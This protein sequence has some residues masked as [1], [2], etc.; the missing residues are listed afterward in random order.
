MFWRLRSAHATVLRKRNFTY[1]KEVGVS[2]CEL[3]DLPT[4]YCS[5]LSSGQTK[6]LQSNVT[7]SVPTEPLDYLFTLRKINR[8]VSVLV[9]TLQYTK[10][11]RLSSPVKQLGDGFALTARCNYRCVDSSF[12]CILI[13]F[14]GSFLPAE[15]KRLSRFTKGDT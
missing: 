5:R 8:A 14:W 10:S 2:Y 1:V 12:F 3:I 9:L 7:S 6:Q 11:V 15:A 4:P 13:D